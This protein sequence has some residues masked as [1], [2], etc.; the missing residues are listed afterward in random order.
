MN[1]LQVKSAI[2]L[3]DVQLTLHRKLRGALIIILNGI[4]KKKEQSIS[5]LLENAGVSAVLTAIAE[6]EEKIKL[7]SILKE[8]EEIIIKEEKIKEEKLRQEKDNQ[9]EE[10]EEEEDEALYLA[11]VAAGKKKPSATK[12]SPYHK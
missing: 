1:E 7:Y 9:E 3:I 12:R 4:A 10:S 2:Q 11:I 5:S 8:N 6:C